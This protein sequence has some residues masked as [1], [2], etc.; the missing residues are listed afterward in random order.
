MFT[1]K[2]FTNNCRTDI[3]RN[4]FCKDSLALNSSIGKG[5]L[6]IFSVGSVDLW[7]HDT[8]LV[9]IWSSFHECL[10]SLILVNFIHS[11]FFLFLSSGEGVESCDISSFPLEFTRSRVSV[12]IP[13]PPPPSPS[14]SRPSFTTCTLRQ[15]ELQ[16][17]QTLYSA[18]KNTSSFKFN[19]QD[20][21]G[22]VHVHVSG[23]IVEPLY[24]QEQKVL[25]SEV[26]WSPN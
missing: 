5:T 19:V 24:T 17:A 7:N 25:I 16:L 20:E 13:S 15:K 21:G 9:E 22:H 2:V 23:Y 1:T 12:E 6:V 14:L 3:D 11:N 4:H 8:S 10:D 26:R 18:H